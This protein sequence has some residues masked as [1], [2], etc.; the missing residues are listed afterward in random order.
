MKNL[1]LSADLPINSET[2]QISVKSSKE[3]ITVNLVG[4]SA[5]YLPFRFILQ[6]FKNKAAL[7]NINQKVVVLQNSQPFLVLKGRTIR[8][9]NYWLAFKYLV[10][11]AIG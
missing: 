10:K 11:S 9:S 6:L 3:V 8:C 7:D 5:L 4:K 2:H 1:V